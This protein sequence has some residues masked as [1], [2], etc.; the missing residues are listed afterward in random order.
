[1]RIFDPKTTL[2]FNVPASD[3]YL[4][5]YENS[6]YDEFL[7]VLNVLL[8]IFMMNKILFYQKIQKTLGLLSTLII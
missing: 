1:M 4:G 2:I 3:F 6:E 7:V 8:V 5:F